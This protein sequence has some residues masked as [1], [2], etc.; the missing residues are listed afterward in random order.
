[1]EVIANRYEWL[2]DSDVSLWRE[3]VDSL[4]LKW[5]R[6]AYWIVIATFFW[7]YRRLGRMI[8]T[9]RYRCCK[10]T[11][12]VQDYKWAS[13]FY[14]SSRG[15][16][17]LWV[18]R[19]SRVLAAK[20][21]SYWIDSCTRSAW[22]RRGVLRGTS[23]RPLTHRHLSRHS[24]TKRH[25]R[26]FL[27]L[28]NTRSPHRIFGIDWNYW[29]FL[30]VCMS[31]SLLQLQ[32]GSTRLAINA[33]SY[34]QDYSN[35]FVHAIDWIVY[36]ILKRSIVILHGDLW[37]KHRSSMQDPQ[38]KLVLPCL[39]VLRDPINLRRIVEQIS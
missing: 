21:L 19:L 31:N 37:W 34:H 11:L 27:L 30:L 20:Y 15:G 17:L 16:R 32:P 3:R 14:K 2:C 5:L 9:R 38:I 24:R 1:M 7:R 26:H 35:Y 25:F 10:R 33:H 8:Y 22:V 13:R 28:K 6:N 4:E 29:Q 23:F 39:S 12:R 36:F 18:F